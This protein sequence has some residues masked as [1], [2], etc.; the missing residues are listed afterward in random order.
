MFY[1]HKKT[2]RLLIKFAPRP[3]CIQLFTATF[4]PLKSKNVKKKFILIYLVNNDN[5]LE[6]RAQK[7]IPYYLKLLFN[8]ENE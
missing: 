4:I 1:N 3:N 7:A 2:N 5:F 8:I 6:K